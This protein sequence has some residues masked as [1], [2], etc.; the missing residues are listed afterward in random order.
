MK[1]GVRVT[2]PPK[3]AFIAPREVSRVPSVPDTRETASFSVRLSSCGAMKAPFGGRIKSAHRSLRSVEQRWL[4]YLS[5]SGNVR[6]CGLSEQRLKGVFV[7]NR[8]A[9]IAG[10]GEFASGVGSRDHEVGLLRDAARCAAAVLL[11]QRLNLIARET[12]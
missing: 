6:G 11:D 1:P 9:E 2:L 12:G 7:E 10:F 3:G 8:H 4:C 5:C